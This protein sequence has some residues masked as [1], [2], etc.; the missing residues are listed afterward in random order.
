MMVICCGG[1]TSSCRAGHGVN[2]WPLYY[3]LSACRVLCIIALISFPPFPVAA[4]FVP[5]G[6]GVEFRYAYYMCMCNATMHVMS[7]LV[8]NKTTHL[9]DPCCCFVHGRGRLVKRQSGRLTRRVPLGNA[10]HL[11][12]H[13]RAIVLVL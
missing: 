7:L 12:P 3:S 8:K 2:S 5:A 4:P 1:D 9:T 10:S 11:D 6:R 13:S